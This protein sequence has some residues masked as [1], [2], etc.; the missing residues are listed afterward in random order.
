MH[1]SHSDLWAT[2]FCVFFQCT[3]RFVILHL[4]IFSLSVCHC[5]CQISNHT[6]WHLVTPDKYWLCTVN[7]G[8][9]ETAINKVS[10]KTHVHKCTEYL[11]LWSKQSRATFEVKVTVYVNVSLWHCGQ[12][13]E[14]CMVSLKAER[15]STLRLLHLQ[16]LPLPPS[17]GSW[18]HYSGAHSSPQRL[19][20]VKTPKATLS[21][22][23]EMHGPLQTHRSWYYCGT[24]CWSELMKCH[25]RFHWVVCKD[26][27][28]TT[29]YNKK[30]TAIQQLT[31]LEALCYML[32]VCLHTDYKA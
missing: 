12:I 32:H 7:R 31:Y 15:Y 20:I 14:W 10:W 17:T 28:V 5:I 16:P 25:L 13:I 27:S 11:K 21:R 8:G 4:W 23:V 19:D 2:E 26:F 1:L 30:T 24:V 18:P 22:A 29:N 3:A 6:C 9:G